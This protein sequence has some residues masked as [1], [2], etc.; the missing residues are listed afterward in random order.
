M[1]HLCL[2]RGRCAGTDSR[3]LDAGHRYE[4][5]VR[6]T[7]APGRESSWRG[8]FCNR[9]LKKLPGLDTSRRLIR[10]YSIIEVGNFPGRLI[11]LLLERCSAHSVNPRQISPRNISIWCFI[12]CEGHCRHEAC[13][14]RWDCSTSH[15]QPAQALDSSPRNIRLR[16]ACR[17]ARVTYQ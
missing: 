1:S 4:Q 7:A 5:R 16:E 2:V 8:I 12:P 13:C 6:T 3:N 10:Y 17:I 14:R 9:S 15:E 11:P